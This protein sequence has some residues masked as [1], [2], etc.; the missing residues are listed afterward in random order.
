MWQCVRSKKSFFKL[1][2]MKASLHITKRQLEIDRDR[3]AAVGSVQGFSS[4]VSSSEMRS[5]S[6][7]SNG[8]QHP[9]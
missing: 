9:G 3:G 7:L 4:I 5:W 8:V 1:P 2:Y 6:P